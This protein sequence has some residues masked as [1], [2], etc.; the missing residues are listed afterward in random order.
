[1]YYTR[2]GSVYST[3]IDTR[4]TSTITTLP[5][6]IRGGSGFAVNADDTFLAGSYVEG[7]ARGG[8]QPSGSGGGLEAR[9]AA[10]L[11]MRLYTINIKTGEIKTFHPSTEWLN[12]VQFSPTDPALIMFCHEGPWHKVDR[13]WTDPHRRH[14]A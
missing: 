14:R 13:I 12:H 3:E 7:E 11:P 1:M 9:W 8:W 4:R 6:E 2:D 10:H 5:P